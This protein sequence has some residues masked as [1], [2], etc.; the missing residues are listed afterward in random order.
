MRYSSE[1]LVVH[2]IAAQSRASADDKSEK[3]LGEKKR[4]ERSNTWNLIKVGT[5][6][7]RGSLIRPQTRWMATGRTAHISRFSGL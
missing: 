7:F 4:T 6:F 1:P 3:A 5:N 2:R